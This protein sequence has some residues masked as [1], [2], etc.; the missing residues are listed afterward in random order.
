M[1]KYTLLIIA[2]LVI[3]FSGCSKSDDVI[4]SS[5]TIGG[6][7]DV[8]VELNRDTTIYQTLNINRTAGSDENISI[9]SDYSY[10]YYNV[11]VSP[12]A[13]SSQS[14]FSP[15]FTYHISPT[16]VGTIPMSLVVSIGSVGSKTYSF[17][18]KIK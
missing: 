3:I 14:S 13:I 11:T 15:V 17:N 4:R 10:N 7:K 1:N 9:W 6:L 16:A 5:Y 2:L 12:S 18:V 8:T